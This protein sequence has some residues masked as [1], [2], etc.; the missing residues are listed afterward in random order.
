[1]ICRQCV[2]L[3]LERTPGLDENGFNFPAKYKAAVEAIF[4]Q[5][6]EII[7]VHFYTFI[8]LTL[9]EVGQDYIW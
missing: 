9:I 6:K 8:H 3:W 4:R 5:E 2:E 7:E 1:M